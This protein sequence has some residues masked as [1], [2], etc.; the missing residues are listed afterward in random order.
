MHALARAEEC[1]AADWSGA[2]THPGEKTCRRKDV[3]VDFSGEPRYVDD[4]ND[5]VG[6]NGLGISRKKKKKK[7]DLV[8]SIFPVSGTN[9]VYFEVERG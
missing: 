1:E 5:V 2:V 7:K 4:E 3:A 8:L 9:Y 6:S